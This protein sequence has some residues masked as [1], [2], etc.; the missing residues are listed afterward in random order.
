[1]SASKQFPSKRGSFFSI[2]AR[3]DK[4]EE[5]S[6]TEHFQEH[7]REITQGKKEVAGRI[8]LL[9]QLGAEWLE[10]EGGLLSEIDPAAGTYEIRATG[11]PDP[12]VSAGEVTDHSST[13]CRVVIAE[14]K[15]LAIENASEQGFARDPEHEFFGLSTYF[16]AKVVV[17]G[18]LYGTLCFVD[19]EPRSEPFDDA[20]ATILAHTV[21]AVEQ[22]L[23]RNRQETRL[24]P[25]PARLEAL[26][27]G[28]PDMLYLHDGEGNL[29][30]PNPRLC[31]KTGYE[32]RELTRMKVWELAPELEADAARARWRSMAP[33]ERRRMETRYRRNGGDTFPVEAT[34]RRLDLDEDR[35]IVSA[36]DVS[37]RN[38]QKR[39]LRR[40]KERFESLV[41]EVE[42]YAIFMLGP[43]GRVQS[44]NEG[45]ERIKGYEEAE[46]LGEPLSTFYTAE[47]RAAGIHKQNLAR[48]EREGS[49]QEEG[50]R[51][52]KD[53]S[54][55]WANVT[56]TALRNE[57][58]DLRG[59]AKVTRDMTDRK[60]RERRY[61]AIFNQT[62]QFIGLMEPDGTLIEA[63][64][65]ALQFG[66]VDRDDVIGKPFWEAHWWQVDEATQREL[67]EAIDRAA[68]G[69]FVRYD[70]EV[71]GAEQN[72][73][74]DFSIRPVLNERGEVTLLIPEGRNITELKALKQREQELERTRNLLAQAQ[75]LANV[76]G[77]KLDLRGAPPHVPE[78]TDELYD[79]FE[80]AHDEVPSVETILGFFPPEARAEREAAIERAIESGEGW[81]Q[82][83]RMTTAEGNERW[84]RSIGE[85]IVENGEVVALHGALED[86]TARKEREEQLERQNQRLDQFASLVSHDL[87][88]PLNVV[89]GRLA[90]AQEEDDPEH[91][92]AAERA[93]GRMDAIIE[94]LLTLTWGGQDVAPDDLA[95][96]DLATVTKTSWGCV[97]MAGATL[98]L[99]G[100]LRLRADEG[101]LRRLLENLFRN[102]AEHG[103][104]A[105]TVRVGTLDDGFFVEDDGV[106][107]PEEK[108]GKVLEG[109]YSSREEGTGLGLSIAQAIAETHGWALSVTESDEGGAR[110][111]ITDID[112][113]K[114]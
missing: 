72:I 76:G 22:E 68:E 28:S 47:D 17:D 79:L 63:N 46:I 45:A 50:W 69:E 13:F 24:Q 12:P 35:F 48:A 94:D 34:L 54:R 61:E 60:K 56:I 15:A 5:T 37:V 84:V 98:D 78:W 31:E 26:F 85:A 27:T 110:F 30:L 44:W 29:L 71:Q 105:V 109:G 33:G 77:W 89:K 82:E 43:D 113:M 70:V 41:Q 86:I 4:L 19:R 2:E 49:V 64:Q 102:A 39:E 83:S 93:L 101:R 18:D 38:E 95:F 108:R 111:E 88:G 91:F 42:E 97:D 6:E 51:V 57:G 36:R 20:D 10:V 11:G 25:I 16:G 1:M 107:I 73:I 99:D 8:E 92:A 104:E 66:G 81:D 58:G 100:D 74:I 59:F 53:G 14:G 75:Q 106:G 87:R 67:R 23:A 55:F 114:E 90:L 112:P 96:H 21:Q 65:T 32:R 52:R 7:L 3:S 103:G 62:Y 9:L 80:V 40:E